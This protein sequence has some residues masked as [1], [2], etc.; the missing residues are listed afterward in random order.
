MYKAV[1]L[2]CDFGTGLERFQFSFEIAFVFTEPEFS[3]AF[4]IVPSC[5]AIFAGA[6]FVW[7]CP[8]F[9]STKRS[10]TFL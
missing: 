2:A 7:Y 9:M 1:N 5:L 10:L 3:K 8:A 6:N 4:L